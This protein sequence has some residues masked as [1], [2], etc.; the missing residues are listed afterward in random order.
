[1]VT[2]HRLAN[3]RVPLLANQRPA[4]QPS[5]SRHQTV[6]TFLNGKKVMSLNDGIGFASDAFQFKCPANLLFQLD[7]C[8]EVGGSIKS[9]NG[10]AFS[11]VEL[12]NFSPRAR[13][14]LWVPI[15]TVETVIQL[16]WV[17]VFSTIPSVNLVTSLYLRLTHDTNITELFDTSDDSLIQHGF[18]SRG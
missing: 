6:H 13:C 5:S 10:E 16:R 9:T 18:C 12:T 7:N 1:M 11:T 8:A 14:E 17:V 15:G 4:L 3:Q 2:I